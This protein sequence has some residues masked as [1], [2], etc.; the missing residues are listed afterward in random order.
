MIATT[1]PFIGRQGQLD[2]VYQLLARVGTR[3]VI[4]VGG[5][6][7]IGKTRLLQEIAARYSEVPQ[8]ST[9]GILDF[10]LLHLRV[11]GG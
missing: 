11:V 9:V 2:Y 4:C 8:L 7:G 1:I 10:D 3:D 6:G 5:P